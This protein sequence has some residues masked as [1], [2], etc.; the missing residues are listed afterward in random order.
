MRNKTIV[1]GVIIGV[2]L[3]TVIVVLAGNPDGP[4][5]APGSTNS[6]T[7]EDIYNRLDSSAAGAQSTFT[8]PSVA[9]G[10]GTMHTLNE[11][12]AAAPALD[13]T[14]GVTATQVLSGMTY[15]G[16][17][18][19]AWGP[20]TGA[21]AD[22][23]AVVITP[24]TTGQAIAMGYHNG[25]GYVVGDADLVASNILSGT[26]LFGLMGVYPLAGAPRTGQIISYTVGDDGDLKRG[27]A[28]PNPRF[29]DNGNGTVTDNLTGL[30]WLTNANCAGATRNWATALSDVGQLNTDGTMNSNNCGDISNSGS[31]QT[32][33]RLP[34]LREQ[35]S[36]IDYGHLNPALPSGHPFTGVQSNYYWTSTTDASNTSYAWGVYLYYGV[37]YINVKTNTY[38]VW[39]VRGGQ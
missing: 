14:N 20:Q 31:H 34:N 39:P 8:E 37:V 4:G 23:D 6:Y 36:L 38:Y 21:M 3:S 17:R 9:P 22:N 32:D 13:N 15:W 28:W 30:I 19:G 2:L 16:L 29:T 7:L 27:V 10:T 35:Q 26:N 25:S 12:M 24:T 1:I 5:T 11:I 18:D 33:W